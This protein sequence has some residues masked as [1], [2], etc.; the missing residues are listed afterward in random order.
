VNAVRAEIPKLGKVRRSLDLCTGSGIQ[1]LNMSGTS[2][3]IWGSDL[4]P[5]AVAFATANARANG[6]GNARF[7]VSNLFEKIEGRFDLITANTPFLLLDEGSQALDG[8]GGAYGME[9]E[10]RLIEGLKTHLEP[11]GTSMLVVSSAF[12]D[13]RNLLEEKLRDMFAAGGWEIDLFP[14]SQYYSKDHWRAYE[15]VR[16][17]K[18]VLYVMRARSVSGS[19]L[20]VRAHDWPHP[21]REM[22]EAKVK[23]ERQIAR[24]RY[25]AKHG[26]DALG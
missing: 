7:L 14:I 11:G 21:M 10:L 8:Y 6:I 24:R 9:V 18:C 12:V 16:V 20:A 22:L 15:S 13:G 3:E 19:V 2:D 17:E 4:N 25:V 26:T 23:V 5:R 1:A